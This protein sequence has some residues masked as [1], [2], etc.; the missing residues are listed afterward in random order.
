MIVFISR[1]T[2][3]VLNACSGWIV[4]VLENVSVKKWAYRK[5]NERCLFSFQILHFTP[6]IQKFKIINYPLHPK[7]DS[8]ILLSNARQLYSAKGDPLGLKG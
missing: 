4:L 3:S 1:E 8:Q 7:S 6:F 2:L 5:K